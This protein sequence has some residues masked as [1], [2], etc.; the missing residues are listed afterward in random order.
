MKILLLI[1]AVI[2]V[3][4]FVLFMGGQQPLRGIGHIPACGQPVIISRARPP[5]TFVPAA[6]MQLRH[7]ENR[8]LRPKTRRSIDGDARVW[9]AVYGNERG[10]LVTAVADA[11]GRWEWEAAHHASFPAIRQQQY[12]YQNET[13]HEQLMRLDGSSDPFC[14][15]AAP[16][17]VYRAKLLL[18]FRKT[19]VL[20][21]YH[22]AIPEHL[23][24]DIAF[25]TSYLNAFQQRARASCQ[26]SLTDKAW[27]ET[28]VQD[29][30]KL[31]AAGERTSRALLSRWVGEMEQEGRM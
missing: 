9:L 11:E 14:P 25:D 27:L 23:V 6:D 10:T 12:A 1:V 21:E 24:R 30:K 5:L 17:L 16:C 4:V 29:F 22:E 28:H 8:T 26:I 2:A 15:D 3:A 31:D 7:A 20:M 19:Q 13:L 18:N